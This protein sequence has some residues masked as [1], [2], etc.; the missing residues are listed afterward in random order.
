MR[1]KPAELLQEVRKM[2]FAKVYGRWQTENKLTEE[3]A[4]ELLG[5]SERTFRRWCRRYEE[6]GEAGLYDRR[7]N[8][9][10]HNAAPVDE[11]IELLTL[12]ETHYKDFTVSH[13]YD[14]WRWE[15]QGQ[16]SYTW[17]KFCLQEAGFIPKSKRKGAHRRKRP[18]RPMRG[19]MLHQDGSTHEWVPE[20]K[21]DLIVTLDDASSEVYSGFFVEEEGTWSSFQGIKEV[22]KEHGLFCSLYTDRGSHYWSTAKAGEKVDKVNVTQVGRAMHQLGIEMIPAYSPEARGRS[23]RLFRTLQSRLP[24]ELVLAGITDMEEANRFLKN[25]FW[26]EFNNRFSVKAGEEE[27]AFVPWLD[28]NA[29]LED[30]LC[31]QDTRIVGRDNTVRYTTRCLQIPQ[32]KYRYHYV[33]A[34]VLVREYFDGSLSVFHGPRCLAHYDKEGKIIQGELETVVTK[35]LA[36]GLR[37]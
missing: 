5:I 10:A 21:W 32:D 4:A 29:N 8:K 12:F 17:V 31:I 11:V 24:K 19:M 14:K 13:F 6:T 22:I 18:R 26:P 35:E 28:R 9:I 23:E 33:K 7:L 36:C 20:K 3:E 25:K 37:E 34:T 1:L 15:H 16:R 27:S 30:I 2:R